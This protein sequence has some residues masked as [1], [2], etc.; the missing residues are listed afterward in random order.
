MARL[1]PS[2]P[3]AIRTER[4]LDIY[5]DQLSRSTTARTGFRRH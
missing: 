3:E 5:L 2:I 4:N 1:G